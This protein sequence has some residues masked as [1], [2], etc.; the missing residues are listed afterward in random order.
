MV[1]SAPAA[2]IQTDEGRRLWRSHVLAL[3]G[4][5]GAAAQVACWDEASA[6]PF[7]G[8]L[9]APFFPGFDRATDAERPDAATPM[10][11]VSAWFTSD[12]ATVWTASWRLDERLRQ[13]A[14]PPEAV[15]A[16]L[17]AARAAERAGGALVLRSYD[18][19]GR[20]TRE[21]TFPLQGFGRALAQTKCGTLTP[22]AAP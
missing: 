22:P 19:T 3:S 17:D 18:A 4:T 20:T 9:F 12:T 10:V 2:M 8:L 14:M 1:V 5:R 11:R 6:Q 15:P 7:A 13:V 21:L 16:F